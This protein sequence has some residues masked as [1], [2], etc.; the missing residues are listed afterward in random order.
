MSE[1]VTS[2]YEKLLFL[3]K[4]STQPTELEQGL[5]EKWGDL[6]RADYHDGW[7][8]HGPNRPPPEP[9]IRLTDKGEEELRLLREAHR[10]PG[11]VRFTTPDQPAGL[12]WV[13]VSAINSIADRNTGSW[14]TFDG[15]AI[16]VAESSLKILSMIKG[17]G[18]DER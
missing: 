16:A 12:A 4:V 14:V 2:E 8:Q 5:L 13:K 10:M 18:T 9:L 1:V 6:V 3:E 17:G 7:E 15:E 11:F